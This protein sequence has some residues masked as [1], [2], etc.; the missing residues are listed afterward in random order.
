VAQA[1]KAPAPA[2]PSV[3]V[4]PSS[5]KGIDIALGGLAALLA[6]GALVRVFL[7]SSN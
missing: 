6:L 3:A 4:A 1:S 5:V 7:L 2:R